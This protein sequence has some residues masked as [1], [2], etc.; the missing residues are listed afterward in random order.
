MEAC[1]QSAQPQRAIEVYETL[2]KALKA[3]G[4]EPTTE[5]MKIYYKANLGLS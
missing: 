5:V 3:E 1:L 2:E 4:L